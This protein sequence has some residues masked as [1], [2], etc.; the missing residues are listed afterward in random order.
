MLVRCVSSVPAVLG[1]ARDRIVAHEDRAE[2]H[3]AA[4]PPPPPLQFQPLLIIQR[5]VASE[6]Q[7][8]DLRAL[9]DGQCAE[10]EGQATSMQQTAHS[11]HA[12]HRA[13]AERAEGLAAE[14]RATER[15]DAPELK[16][17]TSTISFH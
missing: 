3:P 6:S 10:A 16:E 17:L 5:H 15:L 11:V 13:F 14:C 7:A 8:Q 9:R 2:A 1:R 4:T 12:I